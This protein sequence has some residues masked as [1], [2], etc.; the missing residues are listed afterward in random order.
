M[1]YK[2]LN[3]TNKSYSAIQ[4][5]LY[6]RGIKEED[7]FHYLN[8][9]DEDINEPESLGKEKM[10]VASNILLRT[11]KENKKAIIIVDS[12]CDGFTSSALFINYFHDIYPNWIEDNLDIFFHQGKQHG[13]EDCENLILENHY[14]L[15]IVP[16]AGSNDIDQH[17]H[18]FNEGIKCIIL[19]HHE[20]DI[21]ATYE[22]AIVINNNNKNDEYP[23]KNF[24]G[25][26]IVWQFCRFI[27]KVLN[28]NNADN[29]IDLV[30]L[31]NLGDVMSLKSIETKH[32]INKGIKEENLKNPFFKGMIKKNSFSIGSKV[33]G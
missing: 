25:V 6:N 1:K 18:F 17:R 4:Q 30:A 12:D 11:I 33:T 23:N 29:Y 27:D 24:S 2:L 22:Y 32:I 21:P 10:M 5:I 8:T 31:G 26:G 19:D 16:D 13:L 20:A 7:M 3:E 28:I 15:V 14:D 9:T